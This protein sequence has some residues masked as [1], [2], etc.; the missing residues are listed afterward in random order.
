M[1][2]QRLR[3]YEETPAMNDAPGAAQEPLLRTLAPALRELERGVR[4]WQTAA[5]RQPL[6]ALQKATLEGLA[7]DLGRQA[8]AL[9]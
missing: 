9:Q 6:T 2:A 7:S 4:G 1:G 5:H 3:K 8:E